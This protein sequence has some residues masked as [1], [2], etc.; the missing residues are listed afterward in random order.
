MSECHLKFRNK[1]GQFAGM[2]VNFDSFSEGSVSR[3]GGQFARN[4]GSI[5]LGIYTAKFVSGDSGVSKSVTGYRRFSKVISSRP[6][7]PQR[8]TAAILY[9]LSKAVSLKYLEIRNKGTIFEINNG[10]LKK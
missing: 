2:T 8:R 1:G 3:N 6:H 4:R 7:S 5:W 10:E 9:P